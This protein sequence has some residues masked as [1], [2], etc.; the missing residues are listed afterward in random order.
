MGE[1]GRLVCMADE[2]TYHRV[3]GSAVADDGKRLSRAE[4]RCVVEDGEPVVPV[5][6]ARDPSRELAAEPLFQ[7]WFKEC[8]VVRTPLLIADVVRTPHPRGEHP[9]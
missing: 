8:G 6:A 7:E 1:R 5:L 3:D 4:C 2:A 9:R